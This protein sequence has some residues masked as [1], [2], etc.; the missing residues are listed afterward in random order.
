MKNTF[1][2]D[3][4]RGCMVMEVDS[5]V[6]GTKEVLFDACDFN[7]VKSYR[8][9][10][11]KGHNVF[12]VQASTRTFENKRTSTQFHRLICQLDTENVEVDHINHDGCDNRRNNLRIVSRQENAF[13]LRAKGCSWDK[14]RNKWA[15]EIKVSGKKKYLGRFDSEIEARNAYLA[16]KEQLHII[17]S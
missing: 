4:Q 14:S 16:A 15:A 8:W 7:R 2:V 6:H 5:R 1:R 11:R 12:Y 13:N 9:S 10:L 3:L 17:S